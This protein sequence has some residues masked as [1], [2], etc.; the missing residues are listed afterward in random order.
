DRARPGGQRF[1][2]PAISTHNIGASRR[3]L[4]L[5]LHKR[6]VGR[7]HTSQ[8]DVTMTGSGSA[9]IDEFRRLTPRSAE[10]AEEARGVF[11]SGVTHDA[12]YQDPY[13][14]YVER[15]AGSRK[16]DVDGREY[17]DYSGGHGA[18]LLGHNHPRVT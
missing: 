13:G 5:R 15:A 6:C 3:T 12:R 17:V 14:I 18:L 10:L 16:W 1:S 7:R 9:I 2:N 11:P 8:R 4:Q